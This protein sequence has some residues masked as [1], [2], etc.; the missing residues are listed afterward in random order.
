MASKFLKLR[1]FV[2]AIL[3]TVTIRIFVNMS[4]KCLKLRIFV[5]VI[6]E[7]VTIRIFVNRAYFHRFH[8]DR[9]RRNIFVSVAT[10]SFRHKLLLFLYY[11]I[12]N[13]YMYASLTLMSM[14]I[15]LAVVIA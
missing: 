10:C 2:N 7:I 6:L 15:L 11:N 9:S 8:R 13:I 3:E 1:I 5:I 4:S 14:F 12:A